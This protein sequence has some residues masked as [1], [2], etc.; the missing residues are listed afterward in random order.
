MHVYSTAHAITK[1]LQYTV[2]LENASAKTISKRDL[3]CSDDGAWAS[4]HICGWQGLRGE[5]PARGVKRLPKN[6]NLL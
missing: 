6:V 2:L 4:V 1:L 5:S 3:H